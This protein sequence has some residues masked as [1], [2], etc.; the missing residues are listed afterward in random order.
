MLKMFAFRPWVVPKRMIGR[1]SRS[2]KPSTAVCNRVFE[3]RN[4][5]RAAPTRK[6]NAGPDECMFYIAAAARTQGIIV[7]SGRMTWIQRS[8]VLEAV[9]FQWFHPYLAAGEWDHCLTAAAR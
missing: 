4:W 3:E 8:M 7:S 5:D 2:G 1:A 6:L 9:R